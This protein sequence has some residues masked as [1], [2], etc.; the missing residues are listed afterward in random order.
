MIDALKEYPVI[1]G[2][3]IVIVAM[4]LA[5]RLHAEKEAPGEHNPNCGCH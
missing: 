2:I 5:K 1:V 3:G 4:L